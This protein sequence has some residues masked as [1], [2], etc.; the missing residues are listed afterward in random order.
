L[1]CNKHRADP[2]A[3]MGHY[4][5]QRPGSVRQTGSG[6][7]FLPAHRARLAWQNRFPPFGGMNTCLIPGTVYLSFL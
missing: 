6:R 7:I 1:N 3:G 2:P 5:G 4:A